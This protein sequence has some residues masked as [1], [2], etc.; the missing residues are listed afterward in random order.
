MVPDILKR[1]ITEAE[2]SYVMESNRPSRGT[3]ERGGALLD[4]TYRM[5]DRTL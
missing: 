4:K 2:F 3:L 5:Y 1:G